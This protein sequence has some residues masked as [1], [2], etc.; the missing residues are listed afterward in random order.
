[1][2]HG[3]LSPKT[4]IQIVVCGVVVGALAAR[5]YPRGGLF[6]SLLFIGGYLLRVGRRRLGYIWH[7]GHERMA[8]R[9][10]GLSWCGMLLLWI[11]GMVAATIYYFFLLTLLGV[12]YFFYD[13]RDRLDADA[14][15]RTA[16]SQRSAP[17]KTGDSASQ[18]DPNGSSGKLE[19]PSAVENPVDGG[20][21]L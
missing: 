20:V 12:D 6:V 11:H 2:I 13:R 17:Q 10:L 15:A 16:S 8:R 7:L 3:T 4:T 9:V 1:M 18:N 19:A 5:D 21:K 14:T